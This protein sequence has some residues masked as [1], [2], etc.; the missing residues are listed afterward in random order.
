[1][2]TL[3]R[4]LGGGLAV[5]TA[6][7][8]LPLGL[9]AQDAPITPDAPAAPSAQVCTAQVTPAEIEAGA[10]AVQL[11]VAMSAAVGE[12][13]SLE[14]HSGGI[15]VASPQDLP[16]IELAADEA[17]A[18]ITLDAEADEDNTWKVW[19]TTNEAEPGTHQVTFIGSEGR[20]TAD[21]TVADR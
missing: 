4:I 6:L 20:C 10:P 3:T 14:A 17:P 1:M 13:E 21:V 5:A 9:S 7:V 8:A 19:V 11:T 16:R 12:V 18:P 15:A 2:Q